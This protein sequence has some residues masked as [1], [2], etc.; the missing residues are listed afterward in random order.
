MPNNFTKERKKLRLAIVD[1]VLMACHGTGGCL[2]CV[3]TQ[4]KHAPT[5]PVGRYLALG[6]A[7]S[8]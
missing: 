8:S 7:V 1:A 6:K 2:F 5:C 3:L 4:D